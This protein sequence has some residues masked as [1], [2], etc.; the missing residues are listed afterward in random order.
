MS[1]IATIYLTGAFVAFFWGVYYCH[2]ASQP[3][4]DPLKFSIFTALVW[5]LAIFA[6]LPDIPQKLRET[7]EAAATV[8]KWIKEGEEARRH[9]RGE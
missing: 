3:I 6:S 1:M 2:G 8:K 5:P 7:R 4:S 9:A